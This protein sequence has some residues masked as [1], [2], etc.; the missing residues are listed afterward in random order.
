MSVYDEAFGGSRDFQLFQQVLIRHWP[1]AESFFLGA[2]AQANASFGDT[3]FYARP[4]IALRGVPA[5]EYE[6]IALPLKL[7]GFDASPVRA[8]LRTLVSRSE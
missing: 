6:L 5:G 2:R 3:P 7:M 1:L 8:V 4:Y